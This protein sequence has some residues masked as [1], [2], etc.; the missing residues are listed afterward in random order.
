MRQF[1]KTK[2]KEMSLNFVPL[3][4]YEKELKDFLNRGE[5][6][7]TGD[8]KKRKKFFEEAARNYF[9]QK[10]DKGNIPVSK[11]SKQ[12]EKIVLKAIADY[13]AGKTQPIKD[14]DKYLASL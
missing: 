3:D 10:Q 4:E 13:K 6:V 9:R 5:F 14:I 1:T 11:L 7:S 12:Q 8:F 2:K